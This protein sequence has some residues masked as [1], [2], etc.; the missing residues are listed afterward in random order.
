MMI[1]RRDFTRFSLIA[2]CGLAVAGCAEWEASPLLKG[3]HLVD[4]SVATIERFQTIEGLQRFSEFLPDAVGLMIFPRILK[5]GLFVGGEGGNGILM[6]RNPNGGWSA[7]A[8]YSMATGSL[9]MQIGAQDTEMILVIRNQ[10]AVDAILKD[11][12]KIGADAGYTVGIYGVGAEASTTTNLGVDVLA[13]TNSRLGGYIGVSV[14][15]ALIA[16]RQDL[17]EGVYGVGI[18]PA[19]IVTDPSYRMARADRLHNLLGR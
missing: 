9:G 11:Q 14:E 10:G 8:F 18:T 6:S 17:N 5:V 3:Q 13:F 4:E 19:Q 7:P 2:A 15:G 16:R 1:S 12:A